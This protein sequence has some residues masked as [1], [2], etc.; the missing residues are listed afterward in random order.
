MNTSSEQ[1]FQSAAI[2]FREKRFAE[3]EALCRQLSAANPAHVGAKV[4][5]SNIVGRNGDAI[6]AHQL[7]REALNVDPNCFEA[8]IGLGM[9]AASEGD[10]REAIELCSRATSIRPNFGLAHYHLGRSYLRVGLYAEAAAS[11]RTALSLAPNDPGARHHLGV[12]LKGMGRTREAEDCFRAVIALKPD[13]PASVFELG[14]LLFLDGDLAGASACY[15]RAAELTPNSAT[16]FLWLGQALMLESNLVEAEAALQKA[17][18]LDPDLNE[19]Q[20]TLARLLYQS[21]RFDE[22]LAYLE[23]SLSLDPE[24]PDAYCVIAAGRRFTQGDRPMV[25]KMLDILEHGHLATGDLQVLN[26]ALGKALDDLGDYEQAFIHYREANCLAQEHL[27]HAGDA[28]DAERMRANVDRTITRFTPAYADQCK[29]LGLD[30][31]KPIFI[32]GMPRSGTTLLE[33]IVSSHSEIGAAGELGT[34]RDLIA[35]TFRSFESIPGREDIVSQA[36]PFLDRLDQI[37]PGA[38]MVTEKTPLNY[39]ILG[40]ILTMFPNSHILHC[41]RNPIDTCLSNYMTPFSIGPD[42]AHD[43][44]ALVFVYKQYLRI[45]DHWRRILPKDRLLEVD[46]E[47]IVADREPVL[48]TILAFLGLEWDE[49]CMHHERN[50]HAIST[51]SIWQAR[52]PVFSRSVERWRRYEPWIGP[53]AELHEL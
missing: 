42:Y 28:F 14:H 32:V 17:I 44:D 23:K 52:Q 3:C 31:D 53:L 33:Q 7:L 13:S 9:L 1:L 43:L 27:V 5:L 19:A 15:R 40:P 46:Y 41:R 36:A 12:A 24:R 37:A 26:Y 48:R 6:Q 20:I 16:S 38:R 29:G 50:K 49:A 21:G 30:S 39:M 22:A 51:P 11:L 45:M 2:A 8:L 18:D 10:P 47:A 34:W 4:L 25:Q 35:G